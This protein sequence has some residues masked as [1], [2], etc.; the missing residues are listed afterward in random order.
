M[1]KQRLTVGVS[2]RGTYTLQDTD[3]VLPEDKSVLE[4]M[5]WVFTDYFDTPDNLITFL[6]LK[7]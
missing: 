1:E 7:E 3:K 4:K 6:G 2:P 5:G